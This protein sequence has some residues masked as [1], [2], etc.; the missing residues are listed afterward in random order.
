MR[1]ISTPKRELDRAPG[2][3]GI[4]CGS[5]TRVPGLKVRRPRPSRRTRRET[6]LRLC[7]RAS[8][9]SDVVSRCT[10]PDQGHAHPAPR[11]PARGHG[12]HGHTRSEADAS[13]APAARPPMEHGTAVPLACTRICI[14]GKVS[15]SASTEAALRQL[16][17]ER[18]STHRSQPAPKAS[19][20]KT[21]R[22]GT[23]RHP[24]LLRT[25]ALGRCALGRFLPRMHRVLVLIKPAARAAIARRAI[26]AHGR[27]AGRCRL[28]CCSARE[29]NP[30]PQGSMAGG[31]A[32][33]S[34]DETLC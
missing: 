23:F 18:R 16:V 19:G 31:D 3:C 21:N 2:C 27:C 29:R 25:T 14:T 34:H 32:A 15:V 6:A 28:A 1:P 30:P 7:P 11:T 33:R 24:G 20:G 12:V 10:G 5:R 17:K 22:P 26:A 13:V 9:P 8:V 4:A